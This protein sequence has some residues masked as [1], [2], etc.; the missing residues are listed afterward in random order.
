[1]KQHSSSELLYWGQI[2][3]TDGATVLAPTVAC[4]MESLSGRRMEQAQLTEARTSHMV[5]FHFGDAVLL[6][7]DGYVTINGV[8]YVVDYTRDPATPRPGMWREV[9]CHVERTKS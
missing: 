6:T 2:L 1:M 9:F 3:D 7:D 5:L 4:G 8:L